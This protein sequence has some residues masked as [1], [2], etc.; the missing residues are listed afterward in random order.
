ME[1]VTMLNYFLF[2]LIKNNKI[3]KIN[4]IIYNEFVLIDIKHVDDVSVSK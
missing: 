4:C 2:S 3:S 1:C